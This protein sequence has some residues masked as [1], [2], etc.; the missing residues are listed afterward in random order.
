MGRLFDLIQEYVDR[1]K[2]P[3][4]ERHLAKEIGVTQTTLSNWR[5]PKG[6]VKKEHLEAIARVTGN[7]Y[8]VVRDAWL[9]DIGLLH[10]G[11]S[12]DD[13]RATGEGRAAG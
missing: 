1:Q 3:P 13:K 7:P 12:A 4:S 8:R 5:T 2:Y 11:P 9:E 10:P 6:M